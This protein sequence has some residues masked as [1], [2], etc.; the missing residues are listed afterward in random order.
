VGKGHRKEKLGLKETANLSFHFCLL[1]FTVSH[2]VP[3]W[4]FVKYVLIN[5]VLNT[6]QTTSQWPV[7]NLL[8]SA[9]PQS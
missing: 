2:R 1:W 9:A 8:L 3:T 7:Y 4:A 5:Y 6:R